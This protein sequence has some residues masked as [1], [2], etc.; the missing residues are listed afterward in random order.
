[1]ENPSGQLFKQAFLEL[2]TEAYAGPADHSSTWFTNNE[3][4]AA[5]F[6]TLRHLSAE[7]ASTPPAPGVS[8]VAAHTEHLRW[9]LALANAY[10]RGEMP[11]ADW[12]ESWAVQSVDPQVWDRLR[13]ELRQEYETLRRAIEAREDWSHPQLVTGA[14]AQVPHAAYHLGA[15]RQLARLVKRA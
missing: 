9:S 1:M 14:L 8:T 6:G 13:A 2:F 15:I 3:P 4:D 12:E 7:E 10:V 5:L 11:Q